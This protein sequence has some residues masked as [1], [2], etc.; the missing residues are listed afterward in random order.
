MSEVNEAASTRVP[1]ESAVK[2][3]A[4]AAGIA[5]GLSFRKN[6]RFEVD[7]HAEVRVH[8]DTIGNSVLRGR[9]LDISTSGCYI[10]TMA[11]VPIPPETEVNIDFSVYGYVFRVRAASRFA[12]SKVGIGFRFLTMDEVTKQRLYMVLGDIRSKLIEE[13]P[14]GSV[15]V[16]ERTKLDD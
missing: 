12:K 6:E 2:N 14:N 9:I 1:G 5:K 8:S 11:R 4:T 16:V 13:A 15:P 10:Q 7:G 3:D